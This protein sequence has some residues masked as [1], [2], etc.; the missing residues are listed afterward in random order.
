MK[1]GFNYVLGIY[2]E[3]FMLVFVACIKH[4]EN[5]QSYD[6]VWQLLN[7]TLYSVCSQT[8]QNFRVI[9]V[10]DKKQPL[11]HHEEIINRYTEFVEVDFPSHGEDVLNNFELLGDLSPPLHDPKWWS[12]WQEN[13]FATTRP[14]GYFHIANVVLNMASKFLV[15]ILAAKKFDPEYLIFFDG[16]DFVG[17]DISAYLNSHPDENGWIMTHGYK[18]VGNRLAPIYNPKSFCGT[19]NILKYTLL[20]EFIGAELSEKSTQNDLFEHIDSEFLITLGKHQ[21]IRSFFAKKVKPLLEYP[22]RSVLYQISH[23]ESSEHTMRIIRGLPTD[24]LQQK[25]KF[26]KTMPISAPL[27][28]YFNV[29]SKEPVK[30]FGLGFHKTGTTSLELLLQDM[31]YQVAS[32]YKNREKNHTIMLERG[33]LSELK[34]VTGLFDAFQDAPWFLFY[35]EFDQW[36][37]DSKFILTLRDG[38]SW[39][40]S[41]EN[42]F[43]KENIP[44]FNFIYGFD[45]PVGYEDIFIQKFESHNREVIEYF[46]ERPD[47]LLIVDVSEKSAL[48]KISTF[49]GKSSSYLEMPHA[50]A[51]LSSPSKN[52]SKKK[53]KRKRKRKRIVGHLRKIKKTIKQISKPYNF[54]I[55]K[56]ML[57]AP[58]IISGSKKSGAEFLLSV[59]SCHPNIHAIRNM[60]VTYQTNHPLALSPDRFYK[61]NQDDTI[62]E[63]PIDLPHLN[64]LLR[65][66]KK[67]LFS[68]RWCGTNRLS[69]L[70]YDQFLDYYGNKVRILNLIR[71]GR[72]V[73]SEPDNKI[74]GRYSVPSERWVYDVKEGMKFCDHPQVL[75]IRYEDLIQDYEETISR[76]CEFIGEKDPAPFFNYPKSATI[77]EDKY[78][79]GKGQQPQYSDQIEHLLQTPGAME[80]L[81]Y[82]GYID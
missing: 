24:R 47:D 70:M 49:L 72:D 17:N 62:P 27:V 32:P 48:Q 31:G 1:K 14:E 82:Y 44:L 6:K 55:K 37:P 18:M 11:Q 63:S 10:C 21:N 45:N 65:R 67:S 39:W 69:V 15:G 64:A 4:P 5:S 75:T 35:K 12:R 3:I 40:K 25:K 46:K 7:N 68:K 9:V 56:L 43:H 80:S 36:Y 20:L 71:D 28:D 19:G 22:S 81:K 61:T 38:H 41:F 8:D 60:K 66:E 34:K 30:V 74:M 78:W 50:N 77:I 59:L 58:I 33:D 16:D 29:L 79:I 57:S 13:D 54:N 76:L 26:G 52:K 42:Y 23:N 73:V 53:R 2:G 51:K